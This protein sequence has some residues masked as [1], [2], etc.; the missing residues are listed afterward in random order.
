MIRAHR[1]FYTAYPTP[2]WPCHFCGQPV[3]QTGRGKWDGNIH[4]IDWDETNNV[5]ENLAMTHAGCHRSFHSANQTQ[6]Q[7]HRDAI[8]A[9]LLGHEVSEETRQKISQANR[10]KRS[11]LGYR[12]TDETKAKLREAALRRHKK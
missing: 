12:H 5:L 2:P 3:L 1:I 11:T 6:T 4:H 10:G 8:R 7:E 9:G